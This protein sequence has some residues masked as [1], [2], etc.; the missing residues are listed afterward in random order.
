MDVLEKEVLFN[1][2]YIFSFFPNVDNS[3]LQLPCCLKCMACLLR[4]LHAVV[5]LTYEFEHGE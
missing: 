3:Q 4:C 5:L 2:G 1:Q